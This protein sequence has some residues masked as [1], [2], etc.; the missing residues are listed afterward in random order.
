MNNGQIFGLTGNFFGQSLTNNGLENSNFFICQENIPIHKNSFSPR[1][2]KLIPI[3]NKYQV[4]QKP[5]GLSRG[6][7]AI[8]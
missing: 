5:I 6:L 8:S 1:I 3:T 7:S 4:Y 2:I